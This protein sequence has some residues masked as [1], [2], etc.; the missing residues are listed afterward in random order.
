M[1]R[2]YDTFLRDAFVQLLLL[3]DSLFHC[4]KYTRSILAN[5]N[6]QSKSN[7]LRGDPKINLNTRVASW[8]VSQVKLIFK[9]LVVNL[10]DVCSSCQQLD[11]ELNLRN[12]STKRFLSGWFVI[13]ECFPGEPNH[14]LL[15]S[16]A[17]EMTECFQSRF[18][19]LLNVLRSLEYVAV[20]LHSKKTLDTRQVLWRVF[21][22]QWTE[23]A[24]AI[25]VSINKPRTRLRSVSF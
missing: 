10:W 21:Q 6:T 23:E 18:V 16:R 12:L 22:C 19:Y 25:I 1:Q 3:A 8:K 14:C 5:R 7:L 24:D 2:W 15:S 20:S 9:L 17:S 11:F 13:N 4:V